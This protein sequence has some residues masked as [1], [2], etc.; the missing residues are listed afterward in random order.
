MSDEDK[1]I[2]RENVSIL[3]RAGVARGI[4]FGKSEISYDRLES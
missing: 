4:E 3:I 2:I 1:K